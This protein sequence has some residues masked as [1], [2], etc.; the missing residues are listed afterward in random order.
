MS[1][2]ANTGNSLYITPL[3]DERKCSPKLFIAGGTIWIA[4]SSASLQPDGEL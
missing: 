2:K 1:L 3:H 4:E